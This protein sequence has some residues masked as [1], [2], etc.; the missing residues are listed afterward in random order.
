L[1]DGTGLCLHYRVAAEMFQIQA[2]K[3]A[4]VDAEAGGNR[5]F[6]ATS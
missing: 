3:H 2:I 1:A 6:Y 4:F 5:R